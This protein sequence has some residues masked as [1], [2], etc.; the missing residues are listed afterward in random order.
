MDSNLNG[1]KK[2]K[3]LNINETLIKKGAEIWI[4]KVFLVVNF[5]NSFKVQIFP[6]SFLILSP[7]TIK[8]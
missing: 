5:F 2:Y 4:E 1:S 6:L 8:K 7:F 3:L